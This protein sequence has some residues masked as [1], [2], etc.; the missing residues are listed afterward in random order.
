MVEVIAFLAILACAGA[1][2]AVSG[3]EARD[4][5]AAQISLNN[6]RNL[7]VAHATYSSEW[8]GRQVTTCPD[9]FSK[10]IS[11]IGGEY[12]SMYAG[13][14]AGPE[15]SIPAVPLGFDKE[16]QHHESRRGFF[17]QP[18]YYEANC[19]LGSFRAFNTKPFNMYVNAR[20]YDPVFWAPL[21]YTMPKDVK[22]FFEVPAQ[23]PGEGTPFYFSTYCQSMSAM[24]NPEVFSAEKGFRDPRTIESG[25]RSPT[26]AQARYPDLKTH[27]L[28]H[29]WLIDRPSDAMP[30]TGG[31]PWFFNLG[32][33]STPATLFYDGHV[34]PLQVGDVIDSNARIVESGEHSLWIEKE[35]SCHDGGYFTQYT[36]EADSETPTS[37]H[38]FTADGI[39]GRDILPVKD[40]DGEEPGD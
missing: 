39:L 11:R 14:G 18:F 40:A 5:A 37:F 3:Q 34:Q 21:D 17:I 31:T 12:K 6:L 29:L 1:M 22:K 25:F 28:E 15:A 26:L 4:Q 32:R 33:K 7:G 8:N 9:D 23:W 2:L 20:V 10:I 36:H 35:T 38:V 13:E 19:S 16:G 27:M 24:L 30:G